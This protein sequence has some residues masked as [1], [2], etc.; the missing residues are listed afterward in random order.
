M[1][2]YYVNKF[3]YQVDRDPA[4]LAAYKADPAS[5]VERWQDEYG[6]WLGASNRVEQTTWLSFTDGERTAL[7]EHDYATLFELG[8]HF[9]LTLTIFIALYNDDYETKAGPLAF[10]REYAE[11]LSHWLGR[12]YP[13][14]AL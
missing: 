1:S 5:L 9:F 14:V 8:A 11:K 6:R 7:I 10:Q 12:D 3:L 4:L 2:K 13:T